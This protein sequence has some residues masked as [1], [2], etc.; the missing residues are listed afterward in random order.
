MSLLETGLLSGF[1]FPCGQRCFPR[2]LCYVEQ[3]AL[4]HVAQNVLLGGIVQQKPVIAGF[5]SGRR[6]RRRYRAERT[7]PVP[8][9]AMRRAFN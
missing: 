8:Y 9:R 4:A 5:G 2:I 7:V 6:H 1:L 3:R